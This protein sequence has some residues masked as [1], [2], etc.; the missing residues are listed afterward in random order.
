MFQYSNS[1][2]CAVKHTTIS[3]A[4]VDRHR[5]NS[6]LAGLQRE[7]VSKQT[8]HWDNEVRRSP[9]QLK[10][11][12]LRSR[13]NATKLTSKK[14]CRYSKT[15]KPYIRLESGEVGPRVNGAG[16]GDLRQQTANARLKLVC[17]ADRPG[18][19]CKNET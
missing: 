19:S 3:T 11:H 13:P 9:T 5:C 4:L 18:S 2:T 1:S 7:S 10:D 12:D 16:T 8:G 15:E 14:N 17:F 6:S